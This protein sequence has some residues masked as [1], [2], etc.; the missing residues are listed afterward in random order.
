MKKMMLMIIAAMF[1]GGCTSHHKPSEYVFFGNQDRIKVST[2]IYEM[3]F[4]TIY[5]QS[6]ELKSGSRLFDA[7][8]NVMII[9]LG[10]GY[11]FESG[12]TSLYIPE[13]QF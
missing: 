11:I 10:K 1:L 13:D 12:S 6:K 8:N 5:Q 4:T 7:K 2:D 9:R 3:P